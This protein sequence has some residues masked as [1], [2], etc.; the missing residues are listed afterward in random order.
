M[1]STT[2]TY[3]YTNEDVS[4][5]MYDDDVQIVSIDELSEYDDIHAN[6]DDDDDFQYGDDD[7]DDYEG[8]D[9]DEEN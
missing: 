1:S 6:D 2:T 5:S 4:A 3:T 8:D 9:V 7:D